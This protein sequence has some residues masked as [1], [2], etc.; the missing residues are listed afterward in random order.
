M[1]W[2]DEM[3]K[4]AKTS[5]NPVKST[6]KFLHKFSNIPLV[7]IVTGSKTDHIVD[8]TRYYKGTI[9][10]CC[11]NDLIPSQEIIL[12]LKSFRF[13]STNIGGLK[14]LGNCIFW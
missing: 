8:N 7:A 14:P 13:V 6:I 2:S 10:P 11:T 12:N 1:R 3:Q 9:K 5:S 4:D